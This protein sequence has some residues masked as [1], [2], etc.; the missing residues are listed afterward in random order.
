MRTYTSGEGEKETG[1][2]R[3]GHRAGREI[4]DS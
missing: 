1:V 3:M 4:H 2:G